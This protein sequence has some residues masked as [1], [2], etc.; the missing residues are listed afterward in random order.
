MRD[1]AEARIDSVGIEDQRVVLLVVADAVEVAQRLEAASGVAI[2]AAGGGFAAARGIF[3]QIVNDGA[4]SGDSLRMA[5]QAE[6]GKLRD[7][8]LLAQYSLGVIVLESPVFEVRFDAASAVQQRSSRCFEQLLWA[9]E[10]RF[11][12]ME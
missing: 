4:R 3:A 6:A 1:G 2:R 10:Q 7:A 9:G 5:I 12:R 8:E 11:A